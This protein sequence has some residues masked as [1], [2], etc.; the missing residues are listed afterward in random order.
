MIFK[1]CEFCGANLDPNEKC[2]CQK[3]LKA[4]EEKEI[5]YKNSKFLNVC[6]ILLIP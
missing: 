1:Q 6:E 3:K 2:D 5:T 4:S